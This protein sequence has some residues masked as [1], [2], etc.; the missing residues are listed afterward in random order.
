[1]SYEPIETEDVIE[2]LDGM[3][4]ELAAASGML[5][6]MSAAH[7][8]REFDLTEE[9]GDAADGLRLIVDRQ[10]YRLEKHYDGITAKFI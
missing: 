4:E 9:A 6:L 10:L 2:A 3:R 8:S 7:V 5:A 1:M